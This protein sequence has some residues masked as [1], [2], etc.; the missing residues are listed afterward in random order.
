MIKVAPGAMRSAGTVMQK[1]R[2][3]P[4]TSVW[5]SRSFHAEPNSK[6]ACLHRHGAREKSGIL[7]INSPTFLTPS[8]EL[9]EL[10]KLS[11]KKLGSLAILRFFFQKTA[12][13]YSN[14][15]KNTQAVWSTLR[16]WNAKKFEPR[17]P[18]TVW[19]H[20]F[21]KKNWDV[22]VQKSKWRSH[23]N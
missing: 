10:N 3:S 17:L 22:Y 1:W 13:S 7:N 6:P 2:R 14:T 21:N 5:G 18:E 16:R 11:E 9:V 12:F 23:L 8:Q 20:G 4:D 15:Y 19:K